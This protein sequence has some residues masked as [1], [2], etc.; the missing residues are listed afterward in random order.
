MHRQQRKGM[1][2]CAMLGCDGDR[3]TRHHIVPRNEGGS[4]KAINLILLCNKHHDLADSGWYD[5]EFLA[6]LALSKWATP[7]KVKH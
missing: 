5:R 7:K 1:R 6:D 4:D 2:H 3:V